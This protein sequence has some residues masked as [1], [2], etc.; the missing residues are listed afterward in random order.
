[1]SRI[2]SLILSAYPEN[3]LS[4][5]RLIDQAKAYLPERHAH[6][7]GESETGQEPAGWR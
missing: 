4:G 6:E 5:F 3:R 1:M 7:P 2:L